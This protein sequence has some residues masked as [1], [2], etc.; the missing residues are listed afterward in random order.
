MVLGQVSVLVRAKEEGDAG[1]IERWSVLRGMEHREGRKR[2][3]DQLSVL[4]NT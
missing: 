4:R 1:A 2:R 3:A